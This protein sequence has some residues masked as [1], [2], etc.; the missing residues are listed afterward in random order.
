MA[1]ITREG[2]KG[3]EATLTTGP[4]LPA[5]FAALDA[6]QLNLFIKTNSIN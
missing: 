5:E 1:V 3:H 4:A 6:S 2:V